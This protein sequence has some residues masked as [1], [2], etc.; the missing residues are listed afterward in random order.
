MVLCCLDGSCFAAQRSVCAPPTLKKGH[1]PA[2]PGIFYV[3]MPPCGFAEV[4]KYPGAKN[5]C[6]LSQQGFG[7]AGERPRVRGRQNKVMGVIAGL[8]GSTA[9]ETG[10]GI[11]PGDVGRTL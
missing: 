10:S 8:C 1:G 3:S 11:Q 2:S 6:L 9:S 7:I 4:W 5:P